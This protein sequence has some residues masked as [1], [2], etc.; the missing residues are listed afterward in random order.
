MKTDPILTR[1]MLAPYFPD[2]RIVIA[3]EDQSRRVG[4]TVETV[5]ANVTATETIQTAPV[6]TYAASQSFQNERLLTAG[7]GIALTNDGANVT[8]ST[9]GVPLLQGAFDAK[10]IV[11][12]PTTLLLP[13]TGKLA[14]LDDIAAYSAIP[15]TD[16]SL[17]E[18]QPG[19]YY[20][21]RANHTGTQPAA[22]ISDLAE[23][24]QD[25]IGTAIAAGANVSVTYD[26]PAGSISIAVTGLA[27]V[28]TAGT[29]ASLTGKP[30]TLAGYGITDAQ[31]LDAELTAIAGLTSAADRLP[32]FTG[33]GTAALATF[34]AAGRA[35]VD[36][37]D[38]AAQ[39]T[40]LGLG[41]AATVNTGTSGATIPLLS[42][43]NTWGAQQVV[44][45]F[46]VDAANPL[47][48][49]RDTNSTGTA[50]TGGF[51]FYD[52]TNA[53]V[54][55]IARP[56]GDG[57]LWI[58]N[59]GGT[60]YIARALGGSVVATFNSNGANVAGNIM[61]NTTALGGGTGVLAMLNASVVPTSN[62]ASG[63]VLYIEAGALKYRGS[64]GTI[65]TIAAA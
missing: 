35:L 29:F 47:V 3:L 58:E 39:R 12:G 18:G 30:T 62:P 4:E 31:G 22:T 42:G 27:P 26:D 21:S 44:P 6:L 50:A 20:L 53:S 49:L 41:T 60:I 19:S 64:S 1:A 28:A 38:A 43:S 33:S 34:T 61:L 13:E 25:I 57:N 7:T 17:L 46:R 45:A 56:F 11:T 65:T 23:A 15:S 48:T 55:R 16:A 37:A 59:V 5:A 32:Y 52:Q 54:A 51:D 9:K 14:T 63:G 36:D 10:L 24:V 40:T 8:I 2:P